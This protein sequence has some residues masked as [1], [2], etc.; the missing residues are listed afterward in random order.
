MDVLLKG[1]AFLDFTKFRR[2]RWAPWKGHTFHIL[3]SYKYSVVIFYF[4]LFEPEYILYYLKYQLII[5]KYK[6]IFF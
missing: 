5:E 1:D 4:V 3:Q 2:L 6:E